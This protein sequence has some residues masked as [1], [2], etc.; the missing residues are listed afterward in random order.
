MY[1]R[2]QKNISS[3][4]VHEKSATEE[5]SDESSDASD[6]HGDTELVR[7]MF[8]HNRKKELEH[9][10]RLD[11]I[12]PLIY[13]STLELRWAS[14]KALTAAQ[15]VVREINTF[16]WKRGS[17]KLQ[18]YEKVLDA[19]T[20]DLRKAVDK[21]KSDDR[22]QLVAPFMGI[23]EK[24]DTKEVGAKGLPLRSLLVGSSYAAQ[25]LISTDQLLA[26]FDLVRDTSHKRKRSRIWAPSG[27]RML[28]KYAFHRPDDAESSKL[29]GEETPP[30]E[31]TKEEEEEEAPYRS[32][33]CLFISKR[34]IEVEVAYF[35]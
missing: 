10:V 1:Y 13:G 5:T 11:D 22:F 34:F 6:I 32:L 25:L 26:L 7:Q 28:W 24:V 27:L 21:F 23:I 18:E 20:D 19:A 4:T 14:L 12:L 8:S 33:C 35:I 15:D 30:R 31:I 2:N 3:S 29:P 17:S 9:H 16:R